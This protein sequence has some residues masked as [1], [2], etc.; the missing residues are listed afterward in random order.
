M[1]RG[2]TVNGALQT[3]FGTPGMREASISLRLLEQS[4]NV[5]VG[6]FVVQPG[7]RLQVVDDKASP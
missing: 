4:G 5:A 3:G 2:A 6:S 7:G 1:S